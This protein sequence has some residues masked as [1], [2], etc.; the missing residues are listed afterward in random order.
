MLIAGEA[1]CMCVYVCI[2]VCV[3]VCVCVV[4]GGMEE[5]SVPSAQFCCE[6]KTALKSKVY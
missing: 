6:P 1:V 2:C 5:V 3:C 4:K